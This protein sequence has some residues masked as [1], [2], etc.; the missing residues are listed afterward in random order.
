MSALSLGRLGFGAA[1]IGNLYKAVDDEWAMAALEAAWESGIRYFDTAPHYGLGLSERRLGAFLKQHPRD[2]FVLSTK[3]GRLLVPNA[4]YAGGRDLRNQFD[5]PDYL[6]RHFDA[7]EAGIRRS[8][9]ESLE[10]LGMDT[11]DILYL[12]DPEAY[13]LE[14]GLREGL[15][16]LAMLRAE[17][18]VREIGIGVNDPAVAARAV[19]EGDLD[20]V[21]IAGRYT[22]LE[23][24]AL[25][26]LLPT[27]EVYG[28]RVVNAAVFNSGLLATPYPSATSTYDYG[29]VPPV[30]L[31]RAR[32]LADLCAEFDVELPA[33]ALQYSLR[34]PAVAAVVVGTASAHEVRQNVD[35]MRAQ[36]PDALWVSLAEAGLTPG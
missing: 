14:W 19:R 33:A 26:E 25:S 2:E 6:V 4:D 35:R 16:A 21:M 11:V 9:E 27:C 24:P 31:Q 8:L 5:V 17:G 1:P 13:D 30:V 29:P 23:Q 22:L 34:H 10:R 18:L 28:V 36:I 15:P 12:H 20:L 3:V 7:S 32:A